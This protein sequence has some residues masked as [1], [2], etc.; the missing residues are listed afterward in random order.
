[1]KHQTS[2][3]VCVLDNGDRNIYVNGV[4]CFENGIELQSPAR[5]IDK[6]SNGDLL[7]EL[8]KTAQSICRSVPKERL[9]WLAANPKPGIKTP[10][11]IGS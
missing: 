1:M 10:H 5:L 6:I 4:H 3:L 7:G 9:D 2:I 11:P 8:H